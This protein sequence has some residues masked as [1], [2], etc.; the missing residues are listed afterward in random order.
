MVIRVPMFTFVPLETLIIPKL[1]S[2]VYAA[3][4][5]VMPADQGYNSFCFLFPT[6][7]VNPC[8]FIPLIGDQT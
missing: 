7:L 3:S 4:T 8:K 6:A 2:F 1:V 5:D